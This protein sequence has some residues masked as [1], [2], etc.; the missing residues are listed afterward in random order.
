VTARRSRIAIALTV[1]VLAV[2]AA[3]ASAAPGYVFV[4]P[5][6]GSSG[7]SVGVAVDNSAGGSAGDVYDAA[8][9]SGVLTKFNAAGEPVNFTEG[10]GAGTNALSGSGFSPG[11]AP[12]AL[13]VDSTTGNLFVAVEAPAPGRVDG[14]NSAGL[15]LALPS[16]AFEPVVEAGGVTAEEAATY[17]P[18]GVAVDDSCYYQG[19]SEPACKAA[20]PSNG[21][22]YVADR[23]GTNSV[24]YKFTAE[25]AYLGRLGKGA[26]ASPVTLAVDSS[27]NVYVANQGKNVE[28]FSSS[29]VSIGVFG[30]AEGSNAVTIDH[31]TGDVYIYESAAGQVVQYDPAGAEIS[32]FGAIGS[33]FGIAVSESPPTHTVYVSALS[34]GEVL[35]FEY[36]E[37]PEA[38]V[39]EPAEEVTTTTALLNGTLKAG[40]SEYFFQYN[41]NGTCE[42]TGAASTPPSPGSSGHVS[43]QASGLEPNKHYTFCLV[44]SN[45]FGQS[46][47]APE[48][49][50]TPVTPPTVESE[51]SSGETPFE[52]TLQA[53]VNPNNQETAYSFEYST[54]ATGETLESPITTVPGAEPLPAEFGP[55][56]ASVP[57]GRVLT[58]ATT[59]FYRVLATNAT[60]TTTGKVQQFTTKTAEKPII[61]SE[62]VSGLTTTDAQLQA[63]INPNYQETSYR[64]EYSTKATGETLE[65]PI[66]TVEGAPPAPLLTAVFEEQPAGPVD[67]AGAL[68]P[69]TTYYY[70]VAAENETSTKEGKPAEGKV[71]H[72]TTLA[73]PTVTAGEAQS[74]TRTSAALTG[75]VNPGGVATTYHFA[76]VAVSEFEPLAADPYA[77]GRTT[78]ESASV[79]SDYTSHAAGPAFIGELRPGETY[80]YALVATNEVGTTTG[81]DGTLTTSPPAPPL[82][83]TG[84]ASAVGQN[85]ASIA[86]T[87]NGQGLQT[88]YGFETG[89][90]ANAYGPSAD[91]GSIAAG[92]GEASVGLT[93][94]GL[95]PGT[96]Y[97]YRIT[98]ANVDG[99]SYGQDRTFTTTPTTSGSGS[100]LT[101]VAIP[102]IGFPNE[103]AAAKPTRKLTRAQQLA[104]ALKACKRKPRKKRAACVRQAKKRYGPA[105]KRQRR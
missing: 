46:E 52:A 24:V 81:P 25:G 14:F 78:P 37:P 32:H 94:T 4:P 34:P 72:F 5:P 76:Y 22:V 11:L 67:L 8:L 54:K 92:G 39:T 53:Q 83:Q 17:E 87:V 18:S 57:T 71:E 40:G 63:K 56:S 68:A 6:F 15:E 90:S 21:D 93:L 99:T 16:G 31:S 77:K 95:L 7:L 49:F 27:G 43:T 28:E 47:G 10:S 100:P 89:T 64:F 96:T 2:A 36:G 20:D 26:L 65:P 58:P 23:N 74:I 101:M 75:T 44:A 1:V 62:S 102:S 84:G 69:R 98:A 104:R 61:A 85:T 9:E 3:P 60:G 70:R 105:K 103:E 33:S 66:T 35:K 50:A 82:V 79:G 80:H 45:P 91:L 42:A 29:G 41:T 48:T 97:H 19:L 55:R 51:T 59:Y 30:K 86:A 38:P 12:W 88:S 13:A 73:T